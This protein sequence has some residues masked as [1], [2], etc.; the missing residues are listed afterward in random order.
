MFQTTDGFAIARTRTYNVYIVTLRSG[1]NYTDNLVDKATE[2]M[3]VCQKVKTRR[4]VY[5]KPC[6]ANV[7]NYFSS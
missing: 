6:T 5:Y 4:F 3:Q 2:E 7:C 1:E